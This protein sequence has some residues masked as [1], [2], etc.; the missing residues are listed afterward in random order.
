[1]NKIFIIHP[2]QILR[3]GLSFYIQEQYQTTEIH[4]F[5]TLEDCETTLITEND[6]LIINTHTTTVALLNTLTRLQKRGV[7][8]IL[9][10]ES[11]DEIQ[12]RTLF[13]Q[14]FSGYFLKDVDES[15][16]LEGLDKVYNDTPYLQTKLSSLLFKEYLSQ[17]QNDNKI[18]EATL[19]TESILHNTSLTNREWEVLNYLSKG[20]S[21]DKIAKELFLTESTV[22]NHV[23]AILR[24]LKVSDRTAAVV[25]AIKNEWIKYASIGLIGNL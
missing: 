14:G 13:K 16:L 21:N 17:I 1:V 20:Y 2:F 15:E 7:K 4:E 22:K 5:N 6:I 11:A 8:I 10:M 19:A 3:K 18:K 25:L 23:S 12:I 24:K 9:W